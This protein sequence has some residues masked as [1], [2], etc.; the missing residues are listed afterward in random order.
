MEY[1][2]KLLASKQQVLH[3]ALQAEKHRAADIDLLYYY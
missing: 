1:D 3:S 2:M